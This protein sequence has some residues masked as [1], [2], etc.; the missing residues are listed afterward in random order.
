MTAG[1][2]RTVPGMIT[3]T[4]R[5]LFS[6]WALMA[7]A[8]LAAGVAVAG[9]VAKG[10]VAERE[11]RLL[12]EQ[13]PGRMAGTAQELAAAE[14]LLERFNDMGYEARLQ[15]FPV[16]Y[17]FHPAGGQTANER[18]A[19]SANVIA[20]LP[21]AGDRLIIIGAHYDTAVA[22]NAGQ[23]EAGIGGRALQGVDD[24][25]SGV[26]VVLELAQRLAGTRPEHTIRFMAF[27]AEEVGLL[28][29][30]HA[31]GVMD[32]DERGR[33]D[34]MINIDSIITGDALY[35]HAGP[36]TYAAD[37]AAGAAREQALQMAA[38]LDIDLHTNPGLNEDYPAGTGCCSDQMAFDE[39]GITV[40]NFEATNWR[41][42]DQDGYQ[43]TDISEAFPGGD[44]W[45][46]VER[47]SIEH[48]E[49]HLPEGR[50]SYRPAQMVTLLL[51]LLK[52]W[53]GLD[54]N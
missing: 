4:S 12:A 2:L 1:F 52:Q 30:R 41:L 27:G 44:S 42:G 3:T 15:G 23:V 34:L 25:A 36:A 20:E 5:W 22:R 43:Q 6:L 33:V 10:S 31:V 26:G 19:R 11:M 14:Y 21:G 24:N 16:R 17:S 8:L 50:L 32:N 49:A 29:A 28:G 9:D 47:D 46:S 13:F 18:D 48:L 7:C 40:V 45:H 39:A 35:V 37:P 51:P 54:D 53:S 38:E